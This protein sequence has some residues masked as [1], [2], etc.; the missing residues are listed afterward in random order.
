MRSH[1][2]SSR[3]ANALREHSLHLV[4]QRRD[5]GRVDRVDVEMAGAHLVELG[6]REEQADGAEQP[7]HRRHEHRRDAE[8][9]G[10]PAGMDRARSR[11]RR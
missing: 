2:A 1:P 8:L 7:G 11:R 9:V 5:R 3:P 10:E 6:P 4:E